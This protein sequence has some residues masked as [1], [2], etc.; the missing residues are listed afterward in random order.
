MEWLYCM[1][2]VHPYDLGT[3]SVT[4]PRKDVFSTQEPVKPNYL[5]LRTVFDKTHILAHQTYKVNV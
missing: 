5:H 4:I 1:Y 2:N 3:K